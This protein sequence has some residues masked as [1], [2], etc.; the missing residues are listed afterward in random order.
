MPPPVSP[1]GKA[2]AVLG[3]EIISVNDDRQSKPF[4]YLN[5]PEAGWG[6]RRHN[7]APVFRGDDIRAISHPKRKSRLAAGLSFSL[8]LTQ[9][10]S[11]LAVL[12]ALLA[13]AALA[14][15]VLLLLAG[16]LAA[17]LLLAGLL[18]RVLIL[19]ARVLI[20]VRHSGSP[21]F[22]LLGTQRGDN[23]QGRGLVSGKFRFQRDHC[24]ATV[25]R[26][27]GAGTGRKLLSAISKSGNRFCVRSRSNY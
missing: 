8:A 3:A 26:D 21:F 1:H 19:L 9:I 6:Y 20:L 23:G 25:W 15:R 10:S 24:V 7:V 11:E 17:A 5:G 18:T 14:V 2:A 13:L 16:L 22:A 4:V 27:C 12:L